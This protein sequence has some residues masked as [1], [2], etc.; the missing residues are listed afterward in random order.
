MQTGQRVAIVGMSVSALLAVI[1][2]FAGMMGHSTA[3]VADGL[4]SAADVLTSGFVLLG[5]TLAAIPPDRNHPYG[6]GRVETLTGLLIGL[7]LTA[8]GAVIC[9]GSLMRLG[10]SGHE[11]SGFV[12]WPLV[13]SLV[14]KAGL[15][16]FKFR[17]ARR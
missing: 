12:V 15:A 4:E 9:Y 6:H 17:Y 14:A 7:F 16:T 10:E 8:G 2:L 3:V 11:V 13:I 1:K 5:L